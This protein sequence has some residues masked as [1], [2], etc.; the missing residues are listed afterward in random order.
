MTMQ[1]VQ[2]PADLLP[3]IKIPKQRMAQELTKE[4][5]L[6]LY[7]EQL[8]SFANAHRL[9]NMSK[10]EF[11]YLLGDRQ[12]PRHYDEDEYADDLQTLADWRRRS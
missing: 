10:I 9:A 3:T 2:I 12:I 5:A 1:L 11:H 4:L 8:I 7:R 6:Q